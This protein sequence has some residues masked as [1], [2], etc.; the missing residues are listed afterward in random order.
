MKKTLIIIGCTL[1]ISVSLTIGATSRPVELW[2]MERSLN[3]TNDDLYQA[4]QQV[5]KLQKRSDAKFCELSGVKISHG[6]TTNNKDKFNKLCNSS[7]SDL[8]QEI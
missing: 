3:E 8:N 6:L 7:E 5:V 2:Y 4:R 1:I